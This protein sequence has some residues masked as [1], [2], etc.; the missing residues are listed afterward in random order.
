MSYNSNRRDFLKKSIFALASLPFAGL[1]VGRTA[2][3]TVAA[4][5]AK[6]EAQ[7]ALPAGQVAVNPAA[8]LPAALGYAE[9]IKKADSKRFSQVLKKEVIASQKCKTCAFYT[10]QAPGWGKCTMIA[11]GLVPSQGWCNSWQKKPEKKA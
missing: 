4:G 9:N 2:R 10:E 5:A 7:P 6:A 11:E 3:A 8:P 1:F